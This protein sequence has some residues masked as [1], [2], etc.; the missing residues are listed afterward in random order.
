[1]K[2]LLAAITRIMFFRLVAIELGQAM[3]SKGEHFSV[4]SPLSDDAK[5]FLLKFCNSSEERVLDD[6]YLSSDQSKLRRAIVSELDES[7]I[8]AALQRHWADPLRV[9]LGAVGRYRWWDVAGWHETGERG[10]REGWPERPPAWDHG[11]IWLRDGEPFVA[12]SQ[13]YPWKL[14][15]DIDELDSFADMYELRFR[16]SNYPAWHYPG[17]CWFIEWCS[18]SGTA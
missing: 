11:S 9:Q 6:Q 12:V 1:M 4:G 8:R 14:N 17:S 10:R 16:V 13:P 5:R 15:N 18:A 7:L 3:W 2:H